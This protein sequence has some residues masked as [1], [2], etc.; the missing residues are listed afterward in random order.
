MSV[1]ITV[2][3]KGEHAR[4]CAAYDRIADYEEANVAELGCHV[5]AMTEEGILVSGTWDSK[6]AFDR[7]FASREFQAILQQCAL[8][9]PQIEIHPVYRSRHDAAGR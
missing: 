5:C 8:P 1:F 3:V 6:E 4:L 2:K 7:L 9:A